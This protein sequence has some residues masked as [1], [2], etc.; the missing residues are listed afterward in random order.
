MVRYYNDFIWLVTI[1]LQHWHWPYCSLPGSHRAVSS[2][3]F[4][5]C[6]NPN[7]VAPATTETK[8]IQTV[9]FKK[10][11]KHA[12]THARTVWRERENVSHFSPY[13]F[14]RSLSDNTY[15]NSHLQNLLPKKKA[16]TFSTLRRFSFERKCGN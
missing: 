12:R 7:R 15:L 4:Q 9:S 1:V 6:P 3:T 2:L 16:V 5:H 10:Q 8:P 11:T 13:K 14:S